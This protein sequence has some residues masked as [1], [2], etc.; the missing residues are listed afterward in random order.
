MFIILITSAG[1]GLITTVI[2]IVI[3][4]SQLHDLF[5]VH[6]KKL[7]PVRFAMNLCI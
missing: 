4:Q 1:L 5:M 6:L 7:D 3:L 2:L